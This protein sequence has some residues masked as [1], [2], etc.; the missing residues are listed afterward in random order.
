M[1]LLHSSYLKTYKPTPNSCFYVNY[2][3][4]Y[5]DYLIFGGQRRPSWIV[6]LLVTEKNGNSFFTSHWGPYKWK[7]TI[8]QNLYEN[9]TELHSD[10]YYWAA[11]Y[12]PTVYILALKIEMCYGRPSRLRHRCAI[13]YVRSLKIIQILCFIG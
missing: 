10:I 5:G 6:A 1:V 9:G 13:R 7:I 8:N 4:R 3:Q 11:N 12:W 2:W